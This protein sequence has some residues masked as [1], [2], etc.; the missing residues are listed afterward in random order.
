MSFLGFLSIIAACLTVGAVAIVISVLVYKSSMQSQWDYDRKM[1]AKVNKWGD[2]YKTKF[3]DMRIEI[4]KLRDEWK[5]FKE[6]K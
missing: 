6:G 4:N 1:E 2:D 3:V 5:E